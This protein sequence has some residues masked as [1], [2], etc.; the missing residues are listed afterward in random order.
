[1]EKRE[2]EYLSRTHAT[3]EGIYN[4]IIRYCWW[5]YMAEKVEDNVTR[6]NESG[7]HFVVCSMF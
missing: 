1:M 5:T 6:A 7:F 2:D 4:L 3:Q